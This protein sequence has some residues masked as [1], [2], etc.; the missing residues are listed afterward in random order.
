MVLDSVYSILTVF[1]SKKVMC[2]V[3][4]KVTG[5]NLRQV[6]K[7]PSR[8][9][10]HVFHFHAMGKSPNLTSISFKWLVVNA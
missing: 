4:K 2:A 3:Y 10:S 1:G 5:K 6:L 9:F 8:W 7:D